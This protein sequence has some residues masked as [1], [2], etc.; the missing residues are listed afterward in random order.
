[1]ARRVRDPKAKE[2][3]FQALPWEIATMKWGTQD[4]VAG[5]LHAFKNRYR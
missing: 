3:L 1:M 4:Q 5:N 2:V